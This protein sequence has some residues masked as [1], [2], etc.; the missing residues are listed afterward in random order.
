MYI[1]NA[2][3]LIFSDSGFAPKT[4]AAMA[5]QTATWAATLICC[6]ECPIAHQIVL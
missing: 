2:I 5:Y 4:I 3:R 6:D 1:R